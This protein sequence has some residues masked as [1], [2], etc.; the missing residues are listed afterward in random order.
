MVFLDE[1]GSCYKDYS[2]FAKAEQ[3]KPGGGRKTSSLLIFAAVGFPEHQLSIVDGWFENLRTGFLHAPD[4]STGPEYEIKGSIL[5]ALRMGW[6]IYEWEG[7]GRQRPWTKEQRRIWSSLSDAKL[8]A[9]EQSIFDLFR[10]LSPTI[11]AVAVDQKSLYTRYK[12]KTYPP[13]F[14][15]I[16]YLQQRV[17]HHVQVQCGTYERAAFIMDETSLLRSA[18]SFKCFAETRNK[19]NTRA[20]WPCDFSRFIIDIPLFGKSHLHQPLQLADL[21]AHAVRRRVTKTDPLGWFDSLEPYF[22]RHW[23]TGSITNAGLT[24]IK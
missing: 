20:A 1:S 12:H 6:R 11:W 24:Y 23:R 15:A 13:A 2:S 4:L 22:A 9:L 21:V 14:W 3:K 10:R 16:T 5:Y 7:G 8:K 19:L 18:E 17:V